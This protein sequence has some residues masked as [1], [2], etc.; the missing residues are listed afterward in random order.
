[1]QYCF[2]RNN[3]QKFEAPK[4]PVLRFNPILHGGGSKRSPLADYCTLIIGGCPKWAN[5]MTLYLSILERSWVGHFWD[6]FL[7]FP[8]H[9]TSTIFSMYNSKGG[10]FYAFKNASIFVSFFW[11]KMVIIQLQM[12]K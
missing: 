11:S 5:F 3:T 7:K 9:F 1:M 6:F 4:E 2:I 8:K 10:P 12:H